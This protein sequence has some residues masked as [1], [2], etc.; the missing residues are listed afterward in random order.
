MFGTIVNSMAVIVCG[1]LG[2]VIKRAIPSKI[3]EPIMKMIGLSIGLIGLLGFLSMSITIED[4]SLKSSGELLLLISLC[5]GV[6][7]GE[8]LRID[9]K[10]NALGLIIEKKANISGFAKGFVSSSILFCVGA[11]A[12]LGA[13]QD[14]IN[15]DSSILLLKA[16]I[17]AILAFIMA[18]SLGIGVAFSGI[19]IFLY[20]GSIAT[21]ASF[22]AP[23]VV[24]EILNGI[25]MVGY[26][27]V[28]CIGTNMLGLT[29]IKTAN[30]LPS[31]IIPI[32]Y[33]IIV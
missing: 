32:I 16:S 22:I 12:I 20:Q 23:F 6:L 4:G 21:L 18:S 15:G 29:K 2:C 3:Q 10:I 27:I 11:M 7:I 14:G 25:C 5:L 8:L 1:I 30:L 26:T 19:V 31:L 28:I 17:D 9:D 24:T 33:F 13:M